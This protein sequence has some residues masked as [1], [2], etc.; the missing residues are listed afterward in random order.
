M[1][2]LII[3]ED[4]NNE[5]RRLYHSCGAYRTECWKSCECLKEFPADIDGIV[6]LQDE[7]NHSLMTQYKRK[8]VDQGIPYVCVRNA[9]RAKSEFA[10]LSN[11]WHSISITQILS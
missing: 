5:I 6:L 9:K 10:K 2:I 11:E 7:C 3:G 1:S 8:A 4:L